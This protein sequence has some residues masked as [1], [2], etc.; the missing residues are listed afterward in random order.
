MSHWKWLP[1][2]FASLAKAHSSRYSYSRLFI[3]SLYFI[4]IIIWIIFVQGKGCFAVRK[5]VSF[6]S[7][8]E[9]NSFHFENQKQKR[10]NRMLW[11]VWSDW[12][13]IQ[14]LSPKL[15]RAR[16]EGNAAFRG[17]N[18]SR[19]FR[20]GVNST[21]LGAKGWNFVCELR[22][23]HPPPPPLPSP[24]RSHV[25]FVLE[26]QGPFLLGRAQV[27]GTYNIS[28]LSLIPFFF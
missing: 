7:D 19:S 27:R 8:Q 9:H 17:R 13:H 6:V 4:I 26:I 1:C 25:V 5:T 24:K 3:V 12:D 14:R 28:L 15:F 21:N 10:K 23:Q 20:L 16:C 2:P 11:C 18:R 22:L